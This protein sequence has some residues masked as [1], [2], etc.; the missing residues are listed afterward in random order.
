MEIQLEN[1]HW[2]ISKLAGG[3]NEKPR[4]EVLKWET[5]VIL[6]VYGIIRVWDNFIT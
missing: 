6:I 4:R 3:K 2:I 1:S 5:S